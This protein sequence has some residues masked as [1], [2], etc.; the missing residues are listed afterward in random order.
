MTPAK[1]HSWEQVSLLGSFVPVKG[2][3]ININMNIMISFT[4]KVECGFTA[5]LVQHCTRIG[6]GMGSNPVGATEFFRC[7]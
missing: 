6:E 4:G 1:R 5:Q 7:L 2:V 3:L